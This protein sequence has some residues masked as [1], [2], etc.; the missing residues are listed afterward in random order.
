MVK[1]T[2]PERNHMSKSKGEKQ[3]IPVWKQFENLVARIERVLAPKGAIVKS[4][5]WLLNHVTG[6]K[7][8]VD[9][10]IRYSI[11][12]TPVLIT[13]ECRKR[14]KGQDDTWI[15][16]LVTKRVNLRASK[17]I[18]VSSTPFSPQAIA[19]AAHNLIEIRRIHEITGTE[20]ECWLNIKN[21]HHTFFV[22]TPKNAIATLFSDNLGTITISNENLPNGASLLKDNL[23][24]WHPTGQRVRLENIVQSMLPQFMKVVQFQRPSKDKPLELNGRI[25]FEKGFMGLL[26]NT[27]LRELESLVLFT[28]IS[29]EEERDAPV[30]Q[31]ARYSNPD[32]TLVDVAE[33]NIQFPEMNVTVAFHKP[34][35]SEM[36][37]TS[38]HVDTKPSKKK[39]KAKKSPKGAPLE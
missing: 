15:E 12:T 8:Q 2:R 29:V 23:F 9:A 11:G 38:V 7:R 3:A 22:V 16:Q 37:S 27:G 33:S 34:H 30:T 35:G 28:E 10:S 4:N 39:P 17:T 13:V 14:N 32:G 21:V 31:L 18:A 20:I 1:G 24:L 26:T 6:R 19:T 25:R 5:D 36:V